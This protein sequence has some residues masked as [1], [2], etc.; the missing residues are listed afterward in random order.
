MTPVISRE[1]PD[2][3]LL[4]TPPLHPFSTC[5]RGSEAV[6]LPEH[7]ATELC[8]ACNM[9]EV[10]KMRSRMVRCRCTEADHDLHVPHKR[11]DDR[12]SLS[13]Y[14][15]LLYLLAMHTFPLLVLICHV[16]YSLGSLRGNVMKV[17]RFG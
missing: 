8:R 10:V 6:H 4:R 5:R 12:I 11:V 3:M 1:L 16:L 9:R 13:S 15:H 17:Q 2:D 7:I 14:L